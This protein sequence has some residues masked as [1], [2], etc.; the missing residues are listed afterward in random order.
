MD[1]KILSSGVICKATISLNASME[2]ILVHLRILVLFLIV[3]I[4]CSTFFQ[5]SYT[6]IHAGIEKARLRSK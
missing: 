6:L 5:M 4:L 2:K 1:Y 3:L